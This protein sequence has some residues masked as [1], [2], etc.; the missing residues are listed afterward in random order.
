MLLYALSGVTDF[1]GGPVVDL[2]SLPFLPLP[3]SSFTFCVIL[4]FSLPFLA[5]VVSN[6]Q[7]CKLLAFSLLLLASS[8]LFF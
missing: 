4:A 7:V 5:F 3:V 8:F 2:L 6:F 1:Y